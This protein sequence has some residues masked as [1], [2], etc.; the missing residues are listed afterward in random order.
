MTE[1]I[2]CPLDNWGAKGSNVLAQSA[3][4]RLQSRHTI[5][6]PHITRLRSKI[7]KN[8]LPIFQQREQLKEKMADAF[9]E[10]WMFLLQWET[11]SGK[12][13]ISP[14]IVR[15]ILKEKNLPDNI[16]MAQPR[17][18]AA[19]W[20]SEWIAAVDWLT[21]WKDG[22]VWYTHS[23]ANE[24]NSKTNISVMTTWVAISR[25]ADILKQS[26]QAIERGET[27]LAEVWAIILDEFHE[28]S[29]E[30]DLLMWMIKVLR[31]R[32]HAPLVLLT[33]ATLDK[34]LVQDFYKIWDDEYTSIDW[35][36]FPVD[37]SYYENQETNDHN[38]KKNY[39]TDSTNAV[40]NV[41]D[42]SDE[43][44]IL[45]FLPW[46]GEINHAANLL[47]T[48]KNIDIEI[49]KLHWQI[50]P[51]DRQYIIDWPQTNW[52]R[53]VIISTNIAETSLTIP[54]VKYVVDSMRQRKVRYNPQTGVTQMWTEFISQDKAVQRAWRAWR[55]ES[56][57][58]V[59]IISKEDYH[60]LNQYTD[61]EITRVNLAKVVLQLKGLSIEPR[62]FPFIQSPWEWLIEEAE[63]LLQKLWALNSQW[64]KT[65]IWDKMMILAFLE[66]RIARML[67]EAQD[68]WHETA[69]LLLSTLSRESNL[70]PNKSKA[71]QFDK[72]SKFKE[73]LQIGDSD[74]L[75][76]LK[77]LQEALKNWLMKPHVGSNGKT[78]N[79]KW[80]QEYSDWVNSI[81]VNGKALKHVA[82]HIHDYA[83]SAWIVLD[84]WDDGSYN[85]TTAIDK[86]LKSPKDV[87]KILLSWFKD[88]LVSTSERWYS[89]DYYSNVDGSN[90][91]H[92]NMSP[93]SY[94][95]NKWNKLWIVWKVQEWKWTFKWEII[96]RNYMHDF[97]PIS[98]KDLHELEPNLCSKE[99][100]EII[101]WDDEEEKFYAIESYFV[102]WY[103]IWNNKHHMSTVD[104]FK[105][106]LI[107]SF[108]INDSNFPELSRNVRSLNSDIHSYVKDL[109][110][111][112]WS[113]APS[114]D[115]IY[116][117]KLNALLE[118]KDFDSITAD[119]FILEEKDIISDQRM[120]ELNELFPNK[121]MFNN[122]DVEIYYQKG[123]SS[124]QIVSI[125][126]SY[127]KDDLHSF[128][129]LILELSKLTEENWPSINNWKLKINIVVSGISFS[130]FDTTFNFDAWVEKIQSS[131]SDYKKLFIRAIGRKK[132][133]KDDYLKAS[134]EWIEYIDWE[135]F[136]PIYN[137]CSV[138]PFSVT[139]APHSHKENENKIFKA[140]L[141]KKW[142]SSEGQ[143]LFD[144]S[145]APQLPDDII[146]DDFLWLKA[147]PYF[148]YDAEKWIFTVDWTN[149]KDILSTQKK[150]LEKEFNDIEN[151]ESIIKSKLSNTLAILIDQCE[152]KWIIPINNNFALQQMI[153]SQLY[154][155]DEKS[156][157]VDTRYWW[158]N[159]RDVWI[160]SPDWNFVEP[161]SQH[162]L[163][164]GEENKK[165][166]TISDDDYVLIWTTWWIT[167]QRQRWS[168]FSTN[169]H[170]SELSDA[171]LNTISKIERK[172]EVPSGITW[173]NSLMTKVISYQL[174]I[175]NSALQESSYV[176]ANNLKYDY[177]RLT[178]D[179]WQEIDLSKNNIYLENYLNIWDF[180]NR[181]W[182]KVE[183]MDVFGWELELIGFDYNW[184][185]Q[186]H[187]RFIE[188]KDKWNS[189][190]IVD[191]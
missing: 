11:G 101:H 105:S 110:S 111:R 52:K 42:G 5:D 133:T 92:Y 14:W 141:E 97:H 68:L 8:S 119:D 55:I 39:I 25:V 126:P 117:K 80:S 190:E 60:T 17:K 38:K 179:W 46:A 88:M 83:R 96:M 7:N 84:R 180:H 147:Y 175:I 73:D 28:R 72:F 120:A 178:S 169:K 121:I 184:G 95:F 109:S 12:S 62:D 27:F 22:I 69:T 146:Y 98:P 81:W 77:V 142:N 66:P 64:K 129:S 157:N 153:N 191:Y 137:W 70:Y 87:S 82:S 150:S 115:S 74:W 93:W 130:W 160:I 132:F 151:Q 67:I 149:S 37:I 48:E 185:N 33:S 20:V 152:S 71:D 134:K 168:Q 104:E 107:K 63:D 100:S 122:T 144:Y 15:E 102:N 114:L 31:D 16:I 49:V 6:Q 89:M 135:Q 159:N 166:E 29:V 18:D 10:K 139:E 148:N 30:Y 131:L 188:N 189:W 58:A 91:L 174:W 40:Q 163:K 181:T 182:Y 43:W 177:F 164:Y 35:R 1:I 3:D 103:S 125:R 2:H 34:E 94:A 118:H 171:Q 65:E 76:N 113:E 156:I 172:L 138:Y 79:K 145:E 4:T 143:Y 167:E 112:F 85:F 61:S 50:H 47:D 173:N 187:L 106:G 21:H 59:R 54:N 13:I 51:N 9:D 24:V 136:Y 41:L 99:N 45:L 155:N 56:W 53:R 86:I 116:K 170:C 26:N 36:T 78:N 44:D 162:N 32:W 158:A 90:A 75:L 19:K 140:Y 57:N 186:F 183:S 23:E 161:D 154:N 108:S 124:E 127:I 128:K 123:F 176:N 165:W